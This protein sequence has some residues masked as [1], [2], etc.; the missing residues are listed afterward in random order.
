MATISFHDHHNFRSSDLQQIRSIWEREQA[1]AGI[2]Q[3]VSI[4]CTEKDAVRL[5]DL[6]AKLDEELAKRIFYLP[7]KTEILFKP[8]DFRKMILQAAKAH[9]TSLQHRS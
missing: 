6:G 8:E 4:V 5:I 2:A 9:P 3:P 1:I 7:I